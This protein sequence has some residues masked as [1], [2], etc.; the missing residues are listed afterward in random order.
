MATGPKSANRSIRN[1]RSMAG[2]P[3]R[4]AQPSY[5]RRHCERSEA[6]QIVAAETVWIASSQVLL[7]MTEKLPVDLCRA[8]LDRLAAAASGDLVGIVED[9]LGLHLVGLVVHLGAEQE[10]HGLRIDQDL[11]AAV[12]HHLVGGAGFVGVVARV[13][14]PGAAAVLDADAQADDFRIGAL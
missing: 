7:A 11:D 5:H 10:Q 13:G 2:F 1:S 6:I 9:E 14:L 4:A 3:G 12:F 8:Q